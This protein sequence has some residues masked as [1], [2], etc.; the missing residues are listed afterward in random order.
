LSYVGDDVRAL[1][2]CVRTFV[3]FD[4]GYA[5]GRVGFGFVESVVD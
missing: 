1:L 3:N 5:L 2:R 4:C